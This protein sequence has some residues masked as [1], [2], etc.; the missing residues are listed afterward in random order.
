[1]ETMTD[2]AG[3]LGL[4]TVGGVVAAGCVVAVGVGALYMAGALSPQEPVPPVPVAAVQ[5]PQ[6]VP[7]DAETAS[8]RAQSVAAPAP[9]SVDAE[10]R[11][12]APQP[13][14]SGS[15]GAD[16][17]T[18]PAQ[19]V[20]S[21]QEPE[22]P[23][24]S[25]PRF[26]VVRAAPDG[27]TIIAGQ[28]APGS[29]VTVLLDGQVADSQTVSEGGEFVSFLSLPAST[30]P[31][32]LSLI[33]RQGDREAPSVEEI[34]LAPTP[35]PQV[36]RSPDDQGTV[37]EEVAVAEPAAAPAGPG[38]V[39][40]DTAPAAAPAGTAPESGERVARETAQPSTPEPL[41][42]VAPVS[43]T[44]ADAQA[45]ANTRTSETQASAEAQTGEAAPETQ[46]APEGAAPQAQTA[47]ND[48]PRL[49]VA[50]PQDTA[51]PAP[52]T[53]VAVLR[54]DAAGVELI[55]PATPD[56]A[57]SREQIVLDTIGYTPEGAVLLSGRSAPAGLVRIYLDNLPLADL[58]AGADGRWR[59]RLEGIAPG[60][61]TLRLDALDEDGGVLSRLETPFKR[62]S[63]AALA[64]AQAQ[65]Q[66]APP[67]P[68]VSQVTVQAGDTLWA[69]SRERY[70]D[71]LLFVRVFEANRDAIRDPDLIFPGQIFAIPD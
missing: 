18:A 10:R 37:A 14:A 15:A 22:E 30:A 28:G 54:A 33:A 71:G 19:T 39:G 41:A 16:S 34:I 12:D 68:P 70:G 66:A 40:T 25:A 50:P 47:V 51:A 62:E 32:L 43:D 63:A 61:Y 52:S 24:L 36:A 23:A 8:P 55:Q 1:M 48:Q 45:D 64:A 29:V 27:T 9:G 65:A 17:D 53:A 58:R 57:P 42:E 2:K 3:F 38:P 60:I 5:T 20:T 11:A 31:R 44:P 6:P 69:I 26:D 21:P 4:G 67:A 13:N 46:A 7:T 35:P 56:A 49:P 59:A